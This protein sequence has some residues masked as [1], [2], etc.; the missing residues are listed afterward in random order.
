M[1]RA[2]IRLEGNEIDIV[3]RSLS[4]ESDRDVPGTSLSIRRE[5]DALIL[6]IEA[7]ETGALRAAVNSYLRWADVAAGVSR[8]V[9][10]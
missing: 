1:R 6:T 3:R 5:R 10:D 4:P 2:E 9:G 8:E 7:Q